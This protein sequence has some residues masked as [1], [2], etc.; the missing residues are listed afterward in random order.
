MDKNFI[1]GW[2]KMKLANLSWAGIKRGKTTKDFMISIGF[3]FFAVVFMPLGVV[4]TIKSHLGAGGYDA[5]NFTL[6]ER[7]GISTSLAIYLTAGLAVILTAVIRRGIPRISTFI[8]SF[9]LGITTDMWKGI[10]IQTDGTTMLSRFLFLV[11]GLI[12]IGIA[13][14]AYILSGL[15]TNPTDDLI[16]ALKE[17]GCP[18]RVSKISFDAICVF[19]A[20][21]FQGEIGV[22]TIVC[23]FALGPVIDLFHMLLIKIDIRDKPKVKEE[24]GQSG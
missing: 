12:V 18:I 1:G 9:F 8:T 6:S 14:A 16:V 15:P 3:Y 10:L 4:F 2:V 17:K 11:L 7:M 5:L 20:F 23:T 19:L 13:V 22:G 24:K 21:V